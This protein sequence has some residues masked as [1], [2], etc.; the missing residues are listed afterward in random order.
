MFGLKKIMMSQMKKIG[1]VK[2]A[3]EKKRIKQNEKS[4]G[5]TVLPLKMIVPICCNISKFTKTNRF[6][7]ENEIR[8]YELFA[9]YSHVLLM[10]I[11]F[12]VQHNT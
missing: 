5:P 6:I 3:S 11:A 10:Q 2:D 1:S 12:N 8:I 7:R 9:Y 4:Y